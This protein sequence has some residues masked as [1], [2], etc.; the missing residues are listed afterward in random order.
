MTLWAIVP[1]KPLRRG[2]SRLAQVLTEDERLGLNRQLLIHTVD[3]LREIPEIEQVLV[4]SR[5][6]AALSLARAHGAR[7]VQENGAPELNI[8]LTRATIVAK[9][10][11]TRGVLII[12]SDLPMISKEDVSAM[13]EMVKDPPVVVVAPDRKREGTNALLVCPVGLI[14]YDYGPHSFERH[15]LRAQQAGARLEICELPSLALDMDVP[16]DLELVSDELGSWTIG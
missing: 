13:L 5:D 1:V 9:Q 4:V 15:C 2:K 16:E 3:T 14:D 10:Y 6:Q 12:P 7:T 8:A 11:A